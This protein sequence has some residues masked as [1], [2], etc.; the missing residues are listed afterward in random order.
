VI[1]EQYYKLVFSSSREVLNLDIII[2]LGYNRGDFKPILFSVLIG[3]F[4]LEKSGSWTS[5]LGS[6]LLNSGLVPIWRLNSEA[7]F[8][9]RGI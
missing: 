8:Q 1:L 6:T 4:G 3:P 9:P 2:G 7:L 5:L